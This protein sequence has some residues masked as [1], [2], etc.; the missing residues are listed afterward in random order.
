ML[1]LHA[2]ERECEIARF[3]GVI[4]SRGAIWLVATTAKNQKICSPPASRRL[5]KKAGDVVRA[6][7]SFE[8]MQ[9][10]ESRRSRGSVEAMDVD[11]VS[12]GSFPALDAR[13]KRRARSKK[14][15][16][17]RLCMAPGYPPRGAVDILASTIG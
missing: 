3:A 13:R 9:E 12:V 10:E 1:E 17:E 11:K 5:A 6:D 4:E 15:S 16:P 7:G 14:L 2:V 8:S